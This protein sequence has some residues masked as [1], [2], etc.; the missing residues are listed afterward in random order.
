MWGTL[1]LLEASARHGVDRFVDISTDKA[2]D[3]ISA[4]GLLQV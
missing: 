4:L 3:P 1:D 2:A